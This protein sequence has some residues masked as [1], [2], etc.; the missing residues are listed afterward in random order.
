MQDTIKDEALARLI[1]AAR[2]F[3]DL[4]EVDYEDNETFL[5]EVQSDDVKKL[6]A[7]LAAFI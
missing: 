2:P 4:L 1:E 5:L 6:R 3:V 7:A